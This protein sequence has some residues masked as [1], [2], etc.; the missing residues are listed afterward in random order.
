MGLIDRARGAAA[1]LLSACMVA[2]PLALAAPT[3]ASADTSRTVTLG[4]DLTDEQ[5][6]TVLS[7]FGL[8]EADLAEMEV[9]TVNNQDE[10]R[11]LEG[12]LPDEVIGWRTYS[13]SYLEPKRSGGLRVETANLTYVTKN[14]LYNALQTAGVENCDLVV[15]A[16]FP[17]SGTGALT[18]VFMAYERRGVALD[19]EKKG[20]A[21]AE[22]VT[23]AALEEEYGEEVAEV[24]SEVKDEVVSGDRELTDDEIRSLIRTAARLRGIDLSDEDID[25]I[26]HLIE[27][28]QGID[29]DLDAFSDTL[30]DLKAKLAGLGEGAD[31]AKGLLDR[32]IGWLEGVVEWFRGLFGGGDAEGGAAGGESGLIGDLNTDVFQLD[33]PDAGD[34]GGEQLEVAAD[35]QQDAQGEPQDAQQD[36][37]AASDAAPEGG[38]AG[39]GAEDGGDA[40]VVADAIDAAGGDAGEAPAE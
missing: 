12:T 2:A 28:I 14:T 24:I 4:A 9:I 13:C 8:G 37:G 32:I 22:L 29:Y 23:T 10:R 7:F 20:A 5:R 35:G 6:A 33:D 38:E 19:E 18:G 21:T 11:Y 16:P 3:A 40:D 1:A 27:R 25:A 26:M 30:T 17:V 31:E 15:T 36:A 34:A 39:Q